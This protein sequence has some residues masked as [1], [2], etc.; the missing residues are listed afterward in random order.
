MDTSADPHLGDAQEV[1]PAPAPPFK[2]QIGLGYKD[3]KPDFPKPV[4]A[5]RGA[6]NILLTLLDDVGYGASST[7]GG[8]IN[9]PKLDKLAKNG[10][11]YTNFHTTALCSP[12]RAA[13]ITDAITIRFIR[14]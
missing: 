3:S 4:H 8:P 10:L 12:T 2:R 6:P 9:T 13:L 14:A 1:L 7:F 11:K 5:P